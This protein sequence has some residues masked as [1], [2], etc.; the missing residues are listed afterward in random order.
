[1]N[2]HP[3]ALGG[4]WYYNPPKNEITT[5][6]SNQIIVATKSNHSQIVFTTLIKIE[7]YGS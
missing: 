3:P 5:Q 1:M 7:S 2:N 4:H 6:Y